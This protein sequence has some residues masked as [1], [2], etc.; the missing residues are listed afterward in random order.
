MVLNP[1]MAWFS[2]LSPG[3]RQ[4][5]TKLVRGVHAYP[6][7]ALGSP[8]EFNLAVNLGEERVIAAQPNVSTWVDPCTP[9]PD[10]NGAAGNRLSAVPFHSQPFGIAVTA[11][12]GAAACFLMG[13][14]SCPSAGALA[15]VRLVRGL[16]CLRAGRLPGSSMVMS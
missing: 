12:V 4:G 9:L 6:A 3:L 2:A 5:T 13:H 1:T 16:L 14:Y 11:I 8:L 10:Y 15:A 7:P